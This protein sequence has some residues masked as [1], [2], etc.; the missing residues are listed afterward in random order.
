MK[1]FVT[2]SKGVTLY[3]L[4]IDIQRFNFIFIDPSVMPR[5]NEIKS[6]MKVKGVCIVN[7][8]PQILD[9]INFRYFIFKMSEFLIHLKS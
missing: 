8:F 3:L 6:H 4:G 1:I 2:A 5:N 9:A 7:S